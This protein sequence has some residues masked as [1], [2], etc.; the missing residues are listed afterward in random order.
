PPPYFNLGWGQLL[1][2]VLTIPLAAFALRLLRP[3]SLRREW[4]LVIHF[5]FAWC[6]LIASAAMTLPVSTPV[7]GHLPLLA[8]TE[9]PWRLLELCG[10]ATALLAGVTVHLG[11]RLL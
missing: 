8:Y 10:I 7:W 9:Y 4:K 5:I 1:L 3:A 2:A 6:L 11:L